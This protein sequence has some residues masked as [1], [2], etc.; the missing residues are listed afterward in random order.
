MIK[1]LGCIWVLILG[2]QISAYAVQAT[3]RVNPN[4]GQIG[5]KL[6]YEIKV[7]TNPKETLES[8]STLSET[9][10]LSV[11]GP[12]IKTGMQG[13]KSVQVHR[14]D[15]QIFDYE[16]LLI[17]TQQVVILEAGK[18]IEKVLPALPILVTAKLS[19]E[20]A[21]QGVIA[22]INP[23]KVI[24]VEWKQYAK[25]GGVWALIVGVLSILLAMIWRRY[26]RKQ[27]SKS[28]VIN[29]PRPPFEIAMTQLAT[30]RKIPVSDP[31]SVQQ[32]Y[33]QLSEIL[34][35]Y[36]SQVTPDTY[37]E[38][39][40]SETIAQ[41]QTHL[42]SQVLRRVKNLLLQSD[43]VKF[44]KDIPSKDAHDAWFDKAKEILI[45]VDAQYPSKKEPSK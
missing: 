10:F 7:I 33:T 45:K 18:R 4:Q 30:L 5:D 6:R 20:E 14:Y 35:H 23:S 43:T 15:L 29:D 31:K 34:K 44:A 28:Q 16:D 21:K 39:T 3:H 22:D 40:S 36:L 25:K 32:C 27:P 2:I 11:K 24:Q 17:P 1:K 38:L 9:P 42:E 12:E 13:P 19:E 37:I 8:I 41:L 26:R